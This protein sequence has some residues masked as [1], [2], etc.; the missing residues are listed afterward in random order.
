[1]AECAVAVFAESET[2]GRQVEREVSVRQP[3]E[4]QQIERCKAISVAHIQA[5]QRVLM[6][7]Y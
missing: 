7:Q 3:V 2:L 4:N 5:R 1:M 6:Q